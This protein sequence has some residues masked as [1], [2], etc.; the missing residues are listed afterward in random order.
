MWWMIVFTGALFKQSTCCL[1][2][3]YLKH[4]AAIL[5]G[6]ALLQSSNTSDNILKASQLVEHG[7][8][9]VF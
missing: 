1:I 9:D 3:T 4:I 8:F 7:Y 2:N 5:V 6:C